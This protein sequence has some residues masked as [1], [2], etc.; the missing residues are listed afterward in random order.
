MNTPA[1]PELT[2]SVAKLFMLP[3]LA[4]TEELAEFRRFIVEV[5]RH[6]EAHPGRM[7]YL[8]IGTPTF[9]GQDLRSCLKFRLSTTASTSVE[10]EEVS[11]VLY[12]MV[13][14]S[15]TLTGWLERFIQEMQQAG[16]LPQISL[17]EDELFGRW[18]GPCLRHRL[19]EHLKEDI[20]V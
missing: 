16:N 4:P 18:K 9:V 13:S 7:V 2:F 5:Q 14:E 3:G 8:T 1:G 15:P 11:R 19:N 12:E 6:Y 20:P 10:D 17:W